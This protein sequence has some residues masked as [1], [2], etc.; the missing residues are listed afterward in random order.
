MSNR[1]YS[2][3]IAAQLIVRKNV[4]HGLSRHTFPQIAKSKVVAV[5]SEKAHVSTLIQYSVWLHEKKGKHLKNASLEESKMYLEAISKIKSQSTV[6]LARQ[7]INL[8]LHPSSPISFVKSQIPNKCENRAYSDQQIAFLR[9]EAEPDL[10]L[11]I[12][13]SDAAGLRGMELFTLADQSNLTASERDYHPHRFAGRA[14][15]VPLLVHGKGRLI[16][17][18]RLPPELAAE[19]RKL[20]RAEPQKISHRGAH[21]QSHFQLVAG[22]T[23]SQRFTDLSLKVLG[24]SNGAHGLR[25]SFAQRRRN[26]LL[27]LGY[28]LE[29]AIQILSNE[30]GHFSVKNTLA[31]LRD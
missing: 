5:L 16:R 8:H 2:P 10:A 12:G 6:S 1:N 15:D 27:C 25:H 13:L 30:L 9:Q 26:E 31:Y 18:V 19:L 22:Q 3:K 28:P 23:F 7:A 24:F 17:E 20:A 11:A 29:E 21:L 14:D 4:H